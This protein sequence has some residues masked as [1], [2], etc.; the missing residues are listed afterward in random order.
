MFTRRGELQAYGRALL[1]LTLQL[2]KDEA[3][4]HTV[5]DEIERAAT[6]NDV[7][8][9]W[10]SRRREMLDFSE[11]NDIEATALSLK[12]LSRVNP[13]SP[14]LPKA[15]RWLVSNRRNGYWWDSTKQTAFAIFG[16]TEYLK[17]SRELSPDYTVEVYLNGEQIVNRRVTAAD[18]QQAQS[19]VVKRKGREVGAI[20]RVRVI[21]R[22]SGM[23][24]FST[25]LEYHTGEEETQAQASKE[26]QL[27]REYLRLKIDE[28]SGKPVWKLEP[29]TGELRSGDLIVVR[30]K[31][32]GA[33]AQRLMIE[34]PIPAGAE[35]VER[36]SSFNL[37]Y[38]DGNW[39]DWYSAREF[40]DEKTVFFLSEF[41][42]EM[43][44]QYAMR[45]QVPGDFRINPARAE[46][47]YNPSVQ[48]NTASARMLIKDK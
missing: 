2:N 5:A 18:A 11:V 16:L 24:Y 40:R 23:L 14:L 48:A 22:G 39:S 41:D 37:D 31:L 4:A 19:F 42:G 36:V 32:T 3:R 8:A 13:Q 47:M 25:T 27:T 7:D 12:A 10:E 30:L 45:V 29:L 15:A 17:A 46:L 26:L 20:N 33:S 34:D 44:F 1:A 35:Q 6:S 21:K 28:S 38:S 43:T 9:H